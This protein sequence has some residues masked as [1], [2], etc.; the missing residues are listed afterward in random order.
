[1]LKKLFGND[2][3]EKELVK[4]KESIEVL[5]ERLR[6]KE[7]YV[8]KVTDENY[9][10]RNTISLLKKEIE[11]LNSKPN[12]FGRVS[13]ATRSNLNILKE[14]KDEGLSYSAIAKKMTEI[15]NENWSKSTVHLLLNK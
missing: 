7:K 15:T 6:V 10:F 3:T 5:E 11:N 9:E 12:Q 8:R 13:R 14:L 4:A 1:M 2:E